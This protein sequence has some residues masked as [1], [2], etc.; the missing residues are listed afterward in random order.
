MVNENKFNQERL[1]IIKGRLYDYSGGVNN[2]DY[3][4]RNRIFNNFE[5]VFGYTKYQ[6]VSD[7]EN[8]LNI[9]MDQY[10]NESREKSL[11]ELDYPF[12]YLKFRFCL[13]P[14]RWDTNYQ[15]YS[16]ALDSIKEDFKRVWKV[17]GNISLMRRIKL[18]NFERKLR[19]E[20]KY[21][22]EERK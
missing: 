16:D 11:N 3:K 13:R 4:I 22:L 10:K 6:P 5:K 9:F 14:G 18:W 7:T 17:A 8:R 2:Q 19:K 1:G 21:I 20:N 12:D 15:I